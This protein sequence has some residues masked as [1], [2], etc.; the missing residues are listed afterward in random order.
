MPPPQRY[1]YFIDGFNLYHAIHGPADQTA[2]RYR[3]Y[4]W[5]DLNKLCS[6]FTP[7]SAQTVKVIYFTAYATWNMPKVARH[8]IYVDALRTVGGEIVFGKFKSRTRKCRICSQE[9]SAW[10]EKQTDVNIA[11]QIFHSAMA[12]E[13]D[14]ASI[15]TGDSDQLPIIRT[16]RACFPNKRI[17]VIIPIGRSA[18]ELK[19]EVD[20]HHRM[21]EQHLRSSLFPATIPLAQGASI[22]C[23]AEWAPLT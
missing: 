21:K 22:S 17:G 1:A 18:E 7:K 10:E 14:S 4:K 15:I 11:V 5:L 13:F 20:F 2:F 16:L 6:H 23:P 12:D 3:Q 19:N 8:R 9:Y